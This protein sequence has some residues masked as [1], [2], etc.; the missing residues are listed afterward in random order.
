MTLSAECHQIGKSVFATL[1]A[2]FDVM[3]FVVPRRNLLVL[4]VAIGYVRADPALTVIPV[5][6][7][8]SNH[9]RPQVV[10]TSWHFD[11]LPSG[12]SA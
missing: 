6:N 4:F 3:D 12:L 11:T 8:R 10:E 5:D 9:V 1:G 2:T 7:G